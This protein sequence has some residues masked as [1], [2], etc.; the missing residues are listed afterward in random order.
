MCPD[1][2][3]QFFPAGCRQDPRFSAIDR[4]AVLRQFEGG[5]GIRFIP[6]RHPLAA[7][8]PVYQPAELSF[9]VFIQVRNDPLKRT[10]IRVVRFFLQHLLPERQQLFRPGFGD[11][12]A[13]QRDK[14]NI[15][16]SRP[17]IIHHHASV[18][19]DAV[20]IPV[21][22]PDDLIHHRVNRVFHF[23]PHTP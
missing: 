18:Q 22:D 1:R 11:L 15:A 9:P 5:K 14:I 19:P 20:H 6:V 10:V 4:L 12:P 23:I 8:S 13:G 16:P 7:G 17:E 2:P 3:D 21:H